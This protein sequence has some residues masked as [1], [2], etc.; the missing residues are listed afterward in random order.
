ML[1][2]ITAVLSRPLLGEFIQVYKDGGLIANS[3]SPVVN[4]SAHQPGV[5]NITAVYIG[6][7][8]YTSA[9]QTWELSITDITSPII[10]EANATPESAYYTENITIFANFSLAA[11]SGLDE[12]YS[13]T[14]NTSNYS[15]GYYE[16]LVW[17]NDTS[18]NEASK[19]LGNFT[20]L[21]AVSV[22]DQYYCCLVSTTSW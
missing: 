4:V 19:V 22:I 16:F 17:A 18:S 5:Y 20:I 13:Y 7:E 9:Q 8:N 6:N 15:A 21:P 12:V 14:F 11:V 2:N 3:S 10:N 1:V